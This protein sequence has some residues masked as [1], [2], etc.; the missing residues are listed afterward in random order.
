MTL[1]NMREHRACGTCVA[2]VL[3]HL[4]GAPRIRQS[5]NELEITRVQDRRMYAHQRD[6]VSSTIGVGTKCGS[7]PNIASID[8]RFLSVPYVVPFGVDEAPYLID[9]DFCAGKIVKD[10]VLVSSASHAR[11]GQEP[12]NGVLGNSGQPGDGA[13]GRTLAKQMEDPAPHGRTSGRAG[14]PAWR[15][16]NRHP[17]ELGDDGQ[18]AVVTTGNPSLRQTK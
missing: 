16:N 15:L 17:R 5:L 13:D 4:V 1:G 10:S 6:Y 8:W 2:R 11:I 14:Q 7:G 18:G 9:L 3:L 12:E